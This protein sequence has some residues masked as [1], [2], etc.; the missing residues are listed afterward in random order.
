LLPSPAGSIAN[1]ARSV[2]PIGPSPVSSILLGGWYSATV[3]L[4]SPG[5][6]MIV[7]FSR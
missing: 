1:T 5:M 2:V 3:H 6:P 4:T 7:T